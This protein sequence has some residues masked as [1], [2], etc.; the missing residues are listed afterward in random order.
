MGK[1]V[2][3]CDERLI[4]QFPYQSLG[5]QPLQATDDLF[6]AAPAGFQQGRIVEGTAD[7]RRRLK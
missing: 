4:A 3:Q 1:V 2:A 6:L 7:D 5:Q